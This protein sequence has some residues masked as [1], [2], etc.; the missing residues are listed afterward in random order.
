VRPILAGLVG[1]V[2]L[3]TLG[4]LAQ[5]PAS[6]TTR[7]E[8]TDYRETSRYDD[9]V[10]FMEA[11]DRASDRIRLTTFGYTFEG[12]S[13]PLAVV[14]DVADASPEAV[15]ASGKTR[16]YVQGNIHA[17]E[18]EGKEAMQMMLRALARGEHREWL[19]RM[20]LLIAPI[21]NADGNERIRL[22]NRPR[23]HGPVGG[24]G[25]R[26]NAQDY[27]LNRDHMKLDS[28]EARSLARLYAQ[29]DPHVAIDLH[30]TNGSRHAYYLTYAPPYHPV[31]DAGIDAL[32][33]HEWLPAVT[34]AVKQKYDW[35]F[36]YYGNLGGGGGFGGGFPGGGRGEPAGRGQAAGRGDPAGRG[37]AAGRGGAPEP[38]W[39][40][41]DYRPRFNT[42]YV[43]LRN[44][45]GLLSETYAYATFED[46]IRA[47][48]RFVEESLNFAHA[49]ADR[50]R[51]ITAAADAR[52]L[53]GQRLATRARLK[54]SDEMVD[55]LIGDVVEERNPYTGAVMMRRIDVRKPQKMYE[56]GSFEASETERVPATYYLPPTLTAAIERLEAHGLRLSRLDAA[57]TVEVEQFRIDTNEAAPRE[58]Q[59]HQER[60]VTG[61]WEPASADLPAG[62]VAVDMTQPLA[63]LAFI[64]LE[65][66]SD[67]GLLDWNVL[68]SA[69]K[70]AKVY[71]VLR[72]RN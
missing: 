29:Y 37:Q 2:L 64:L 19:D 26:P 14:G 23:Q 9:V 55:I 15:L 36:Y 5:D 53:V 45:I 27:D 6:L 42:N 48:Y 28:P 35:D 33:R 59:G 69:L 72:S 50:L 10:A 44:R 56:W 22:N 66:R 65:P 54:R 38:G 12:R 57:R 47:S 11:A 20:V 17:G 4:A 67:D 18:V 58:F 60:T 3:T 39:Y 71:P 52:P 41:Y 34:R 46:R 32:L 24:M 43:G 63:R 30:T 21:Y 70:D 1:F 51:E 61:A 7:P 16:V 49:N 31:T 13:L 25:Q 68:D 8:R 40:T 62:T